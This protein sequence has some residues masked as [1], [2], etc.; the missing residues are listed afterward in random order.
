MT[1]GVGKLDGAAPE[2]TRVNQYSTQT[3]WN[4]R[5]E[6][7]RAVAWCEIGK[8]WAGMEVEPGNFSV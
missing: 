8:A 2:T 6:L 1:E 7:A 4:P 5:S 3:K